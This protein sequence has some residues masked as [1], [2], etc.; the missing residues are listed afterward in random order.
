M[1]PLF[2]VLW[3]VLRLGLPGLRPAEAE[4]IGLD[5]LTWIPAVLAR[6]VNKLPVAYDRRI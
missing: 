2:S 3:E 5:S 1:V 6:G 4:R